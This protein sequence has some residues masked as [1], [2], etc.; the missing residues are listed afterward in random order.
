M[1]VRLCCPWFADWIYD[2]TFLSL[3]TLL[4]TSQFDVVFMCDAA[5]LSDQEMLG[6]TS[7]LKKYPNFLFYQE[8]FESYVE[9]VENLTGVIPNKVR[10][11]VSICGMTNI[12]PSLYPNLVEGYDFWGI[13]DVDVVFGRLGHFIT[14]EVLR[15]H[16][17]V[18]CREF[19]FCH[20][21]FLAKNTSEVLDSWKQS[22]YLES[23]LDTKGEW[24]CILR[25]FNEAIASL[26]K[27][28][29]GK[30]LSLSPLAARKDKSLMWGLSGELLTGISR[31]EISMKH[32]PTPRPKSWPVI[33]TYTPVTEHSNCRR[34][35]SKST[36][37]RGRVVTK[38]GKV[39]KFIRKRRK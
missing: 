23:L 31:V 39:R 15:G 38:V 19:D 10:N 21:F 1:R 37:K 34:V 27:L 25:Y 7:L 5:K 24:G 18:T 33:A 16:D 11:L 20:A 30:V 28:G 29:R 2:F 32:F 22:F 26:Q 14:N 8:T 13:Y 4:K 36:K 17:F 6:F 9:R 12:W 3:E 35:G